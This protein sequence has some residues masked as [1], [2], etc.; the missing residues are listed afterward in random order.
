MQGTGHVPLL[1]C[2]DGACQALGLSFCYR[3][4]LM[5]SLFWFTSLLCSA[6]AGWQH[7]CACVDGCGELCGAQLGQHSARQAEG[8]RLD[9]GL[10]ESNVPWGLHDR[11]AKAAQHAD[12]RWVRCS[13]P[14]LHIATVSANVYA[15]MLPKIKL[16]Q[17]SNNLH[18]AQAGKGGPRHLLRFIRVSQ[19]QWNF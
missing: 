10:L 8:R 4:F 18:C 12:P 15:W 19:L 6:V 1:M 2:N 14:A 13:T 3:H 11:G 5:C 7:S 17:Q 16:G 9:S